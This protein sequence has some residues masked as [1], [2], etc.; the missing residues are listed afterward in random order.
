MEALLRTRSIIILIS[1]LICGVA[2]TIQN[3]V[4][5][6]KIIGVISVE[7]SRYMRTQQGGITF[8][9]GGL[10]NTYQQIS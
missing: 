5:L 1:S 6:Y 10:L 3:V 4:V 9:T 8:T 2:M 7:A